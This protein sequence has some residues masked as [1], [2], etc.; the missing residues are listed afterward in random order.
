MLSLIDSIAKQIPDHEK[1]IQLAGEVIKEYLQW[2]LDQI[3]KNPD[4]ILQFERFLSTIPQHYHAEL[5][6]KF[7]RQHSHPITMG[8]T[9]N[10]CGF[11]EKNFYDVPEDILHAYHSGFLLAGYKFGDCV[12]DLLLVVKNTSDEI[13]LDT[14]LRLVVYPAF[15]DSLHIIEMVEGLENK[16]G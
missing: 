5:K 7:T 13:I 6:D 12:Q 9:Y 4:F 15:R 10:L 8:W 16:L 1:E 2:R 14:R 11:L 3:A